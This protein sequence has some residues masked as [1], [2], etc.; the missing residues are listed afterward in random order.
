M[1]NFEKQRYEKALI[2]FDEAF[3]RGYARGEKAVADG[4]VSVDENG[5]FPIRI[6]V[7]RVDIVDGEIVRWVVEFERRGFEAARIQR[8]RGKIELDAGAS[9]PDDKANHSVCPFFVVDRQ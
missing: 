4:T 9:S 7:E 6:D 5:S 2:E 1:Q 3:R 8:R